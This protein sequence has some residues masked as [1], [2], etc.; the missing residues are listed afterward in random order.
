MSTTFVFSHTFHHG[1]FPYFCEFHDSSRDDRNCRCW[2][3]FLEAIEYFDTS[4]GAVGQQRS[5]RRF[6]ESPGSGTKTVRSS[7][8]WVQTLRATSGSTTHEQ[9]LRWNY[10][11]RYRRVLSL[12]N[13]DWRKARRT[14][15]KSVPADLRPP[16]DLES[17][18]IT[19]LAPGSYTAIVRGVSK[20]DGGCVGGTLRP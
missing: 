9:I 12:L 18:I 20:R 11:D 3:G 19:F 13:D 1:K 17:A 6:Y 5:D 4:V 2:G 15:T 7:G 14:S 10:M 8:R 16:S